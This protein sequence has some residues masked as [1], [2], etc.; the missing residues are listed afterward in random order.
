M[1]FEM[2]ML[3]AEI[4]GVVASLERMKERFGGEVKTNMDKAIEALRTV[5][6]DL[7]RQ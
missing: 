2:R 3:I 6:E 1:T 5:R 4:N 7:S